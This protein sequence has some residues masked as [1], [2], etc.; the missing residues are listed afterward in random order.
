MDKNQL[1]RLTAVAG[2][3]ALSVLAKMFLPQQPTSLFSFS[4]PTQPIVKMPMSPEVA[5]E[6]AAAIKSLVESD[7]FKDATNVSKENML[8]SLKDLFN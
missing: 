4:E 8:K 3:V 5:K 1:A 7:A 2:T 6:K